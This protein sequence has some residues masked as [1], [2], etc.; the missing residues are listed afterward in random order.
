MKRKL[1]LMLGILI[2]F[3]MTAITF[4]TTS[5][6]TTVSITSGSGPITVTQ[7]T[8]NT[9]S[10]SPAENTLGSTGSGDLF[11]LT[12]N[13]AEDIW[14]TLYLTNATDLSKAYSYLNL[15]ITTPEGSKVL[16]LTNG[17]VTFKFTGAASSSTTISLASGGYYC[18]ETTDVALSP[19]FF[20]EAR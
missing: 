13:T 17:Y 18:I 1:F 20:L 2:V 9:P 16:T 15:D 6:S 3:T 14:V 10:W 7:A 4:A 19:A 12:K 8:T 11:T 5:Q